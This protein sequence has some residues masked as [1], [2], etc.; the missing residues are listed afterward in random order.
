VIIGNVG[1][2]RAPWWVCFL[3]GARYE[4]GGFTH[5]G[6]NQLDEVADVFQA[7]YIGRCEL[8]REFALNGDH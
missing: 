5:S 2:K 8:D 6:F 7:S 3:A 1:E 4:R